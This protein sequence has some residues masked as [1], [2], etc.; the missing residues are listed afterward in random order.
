MVKEEKRCNEMNL[1]FISRRNIR[2]RYHYN[3]DGLHL[4]DKGSTLFTE[5][6][7]SALNKVA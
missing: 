7:L 2:T 3:Y 5:K 1:A 6:I 4:N